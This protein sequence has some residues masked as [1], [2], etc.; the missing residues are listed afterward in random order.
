MNTPIF[1]KG[2]LVRHVKSGNEY[3]VLLTPDTTKIEADATPAYAYS[4]GEATWIRPQSEMEDGRFVLA[5]NQENDDTKTLEMPFPSNRGITFHDTS[6]HVFGHGQGGD[7]MIVK[8]SAAF[9]VEDKNISYMNQK[10]VKSTIY[11]IINP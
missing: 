2:N 10:I 3:T 8:P 6:Q 9:V 1:L 7:P 5:K 4:D 11:D